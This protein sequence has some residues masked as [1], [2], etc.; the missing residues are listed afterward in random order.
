MEAV[1]SF[2][3]GLVENGVGNV[4]TTKSGELKRKIVSSAGK[5]TFE[6]QLLLNE[7]KVIEQANVPSSE[8]IQEDEGG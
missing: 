3:K 8:V 5:T 6:I 2:I 1:N 4:Q 7:E